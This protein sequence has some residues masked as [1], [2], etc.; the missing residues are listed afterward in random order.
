MQERQ[1][2]TRTISL[3]RHE[4]DDHFVINLHALHNAT[5]LRNILPR[6]L[7]APKPMY[8]DQRAQHYEIATKLRTTQAAKR[9]R[10]A[11]KSRE[12]REASKAKQQANQLSAVE[13]REI[14]SEEEL[15]GDENLPTNSS[16]S[17]PAQSD[18]ESAQPARQKSRRS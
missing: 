14:E 8:E 16:E 13:D 7:T 3:I 2:T 15:D 5:L 4:D 9:A 12:T 6:R 1:E 18:V 10:T 11:A 17:E